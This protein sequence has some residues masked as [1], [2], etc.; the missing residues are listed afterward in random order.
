MNQWKVC[1]LS[2]TVWYIP[3][4]TAHALSK[5]YWRVKYD[6]REM[7]VNVHKY[8]IRTASKLGI[9]KAGIRYKAPQAIDNQADTKK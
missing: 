3:N 4:L 6:G 7:F 5:N 1:G 9:F 8:P 2:C